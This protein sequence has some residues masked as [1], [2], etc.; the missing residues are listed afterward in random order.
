MFK[1]STNAPA[2]VLYI[3][4]IKDENREL[5]KKLDSKS[6]EKGSNGA[7]S[8]DVKALK[9]INKE[10]LKKIDIKEKRIKEL[11]E[12]IMKFKSKIIGLKEKW[13]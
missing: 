3:K 4:K 2:L 5:L 8:A 1:I 6:N 11:T 7:D 13:L 12:K 9:V 10:L